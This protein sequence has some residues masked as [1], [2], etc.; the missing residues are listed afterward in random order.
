MAN[1]SEQKVIEDGFEWSETFDANAAGTGHKISRLVKAFSVQVKG[2]GAAATGWSVTVKGSLDGV[3]WDT[4]ITHA[5]GDADG[6]IKA[7]AD[8]PVRWVRLDMASINLGS[9]S[10]VVARAIAMP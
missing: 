7:L 6:T 8:K 3:N 9:A 1:S 5:T 10:A 4:L 2:T